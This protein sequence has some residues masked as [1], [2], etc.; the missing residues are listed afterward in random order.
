MKI[1]AIKDESAGNDSVGEM[2]QTTKIFDGADT[3]ESVMRW[4]G[5]QKKRVQITVPDGESFPT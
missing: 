3:L 2:W 5:S 4:V 1:V